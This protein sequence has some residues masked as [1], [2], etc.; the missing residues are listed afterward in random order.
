[1]MFK[2]LD[3]IVKNVLSERNI[4]ND[5]EYY[6]VLQLAVNVARELNFMLPHN[7]KTERIEYDNTKGYIDLPGDCLA[8]L[9][10]GV[11]HCGKLKLLGLNN[12]MAFRKPDVIVCCDTV[13][14]PEE[15]CVTFSNY[16]YGDT[17]GAIYGYGSGENLWGEYRENRQTNRLEFS[18]L[19]DTDEIYLEYR[20]NSIQADGTCLIPEEAVEFLV[21]GVHDKISRFAKDEGVYDKERSRK[22]AIKSKKAARRRFAPTLQEYLDQSTKYYMQAVK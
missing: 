7:I 11:V 17:F 10:V 13:V 16:E 15:Q 14:L 6:R 18:S 4:T 3:Y 5:N 12:E 19:L 21:N 20:S 8:Y 9:K 22:E 2:N 1:M